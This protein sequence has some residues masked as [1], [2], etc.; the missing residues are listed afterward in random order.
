MGVWLLFLQLLVII[1]V[2]IWLITAIHE[3]SHAVSAGVHGIPVRILRVGS[4]PGVVFNL[5][6]TR[7]ELRPFPT[8]GVMIGDAGFGNLAGWRRVYAAGP[9]A[10]LCTGAFLVVAAFGLDSR[11]LLQLACLPLIAICLLL[12]VANQEVSISTPYGKQSASTDWR[13]VKRLNRLGATLSASALTAL[14]GDEPTTGEGVGALK[15]DLQLLD[16]ADTVYVISRLLMR[17][18]VGFDRV[19]GDEVLE[20]AESLPPELADHLRNMVVYEAAVNCWSDR[21]E[22][23]LSIAQELQERN[24]GSVAFA[25]TYGAMLTSV[26]RGIEGLPWLLDSS[27]EVARMQRWTPGMSRQIGLWH[28]FVAVAKHANGD[29]EEEVAFHVGAALAEKVDSPLLAELPAY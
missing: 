26:G 24:P 22:N 25:D 23:L 29:S 3:T 17:L 14:F 28:M 9:V 10:S 12:G 21:A 11:P 8:S 6:A 13:V 1:T 5:G 7:I 20:L 27:V 19:T 16:E 18:L 2:G 4:G 15:E